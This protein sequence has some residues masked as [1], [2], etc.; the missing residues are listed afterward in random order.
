MKARARFFKLSSVVAACF[1]LILVAGVFAGCTLSKKTFKDGAGRTLTLKGTPKRIVSL[2]PAHTETVFALGI[3]DRLVG[4]TNFCNRPLQAQKIEKVGDAFNLNREK[5]LSLKPDIVLCAGTADSQHVK[6]VEAMNIPA[7]VSSPS[8]V[9]EVFADIER[10][11]KIL[12]VEKQGKDL[13]TELQRELNSMSE[14][15][16]QV[17]KDFRPKVF[18]CIDKDLW[19]VGPGSFMND[20]LTVAGGD[21]IIKGVSQQYLQV[22]MEELLAKDP[23]VVLMT[24]PEEEYAP[25]K[26]RPGWNSLRAVRE[27]KVYFVNADLI[28]RPG[29]GVVEGIKEVAAYI[30]PEFG[31]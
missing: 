17:K 27:R 25:L 24:I 23:D 26:E 12:G 13:V 21:N 2:A 6:T 28:S 8:T 18:I 10:I 1:A 31:R 3:G 20:V 30:Y 14:K 7:Y 9:K 29:P 16:E 11:A 19:T 22:S 15:V 5:L 4:V